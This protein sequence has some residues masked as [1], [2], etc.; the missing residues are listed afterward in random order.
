MGLRL[1]VLDQ[2]PVLRGDTARDAL[3]QTTELA[4]KVEELGYHRFWVSEH[5]STPSLAGSSPEVLIAHLA[6]NT[7]TIRIGSGGVLL[8]H[9]SAYK[10][11]ENFRILE[12]LHPGR[13]DLGI[14]RAPGG[15]PNVNRALHDGQ[16]RSAER[17]PEQ[18]DELLAYLRGEDPYMMGVY[19]TPTGPSIPELWFLGS[20]AASALLA[21]EIGASFTFA[22]FINSQGGMLATDRYR[23]RFR[24]SG[25]NSEPK[26]SVSVFTIAAD[27]EQE[28]ERLASSLDLALLLIEQGKSKNGFPPPEEALSYTYSPFERERVRENRNRM[29]VG[30]AA[31]VKQQLEELAKAYGTEEIIINTITYPFEERIRSY[32]LLADAFSLNNNEQEGN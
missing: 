8:P 10:V 2:S 29:V 22:H 25:L 17:Y 16:I 21:A 13:I 11:A 7:S 20:S 24:P 19:A 9:Y 4:R 32:E 12:N 23:S 27:T 26:T 28:A 14:G 30:D 6:A 3:L 1:S 5:H 18:I 31:Q 15:M